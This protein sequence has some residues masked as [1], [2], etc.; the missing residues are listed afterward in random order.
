M[1]TFSFTREQ[2]SLLQIIISHAVINKVEAEDELD[3]SLEGIDE[4][5]KLLYQ[6]EQTN[7]ELFI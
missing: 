2:L 5:E 3:I 7:L 1:K 6:G 4:L